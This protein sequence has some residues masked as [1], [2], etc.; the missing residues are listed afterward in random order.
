MSERVWSE[1]QKAVFKWFEEGTGNLIVRARA[2]T[3]KTT[4]ILEAIEHAPESEVLLA[5]FN[6][7]IAEELKTRLKNPRAQAKTLHSVGV[8]FVY[9]NWSGATLDQDRGRRLATKA[10]GR[11]AP[12]AA[13]RLAAKLAGVGKN[14]ALNPSPADL[15]DVAYRFDC[16]PDDW[17]IDEG[18]TTERIARAAFQVMQMSRDRDGT[19]DFDDMVYLPVVNGW[20]RPK[21]Q[22]VVVDECFPGETQVLLADKSTKT[23]KEIVDNR[24][25]ANV[26]SYDE[27]TGKQVSKRVTDWK[28]VILRKKTYLLKVQQLVR[29]PLTGTYLSTNNSRIRVGQ[30]HLVC[31]EGELIFTKNRGWVKVEELQKTDTLQVESGAPRDRTYNQ[32]YKHSNAGKQRLGAAIKR[33]INDLKKGGRPQV[34][35]TTLGGNG[36]GTT[37][38]QEE[39]FKALG[40]ENGWKTEFVVATKMP[41]GSGYPTNYKIDIAHPACM[42]AVEIDG[43]THASGGSSGKADEKK[44]AFLMSM[45][46]KVLRFKNKDVIRRTQEIASQLVVSACPED[47]VVLSVEEH[48]IDDTYVY[49][50]TVE[51]TNCY[52]AHGILVHNCQ[53]MSLPQLELAR[54]LVKKGGRMVVVGDDRQAIYGFRGADS[55]SLD[56]LK[57][58]LVAHEL[59]LTVTYRCPR[60]IVDRARTLVPDFSVGEGAPEG[61]LTD[62]SVEQM[63]NEARAGDF[64]LSRKN[65]PL[66]KVCLKFIRNGKRAMVEGREVGAGLKSIIKQVGGK[67]VGAFMERLTKWEE[68]N[69]SRLLR[70]G[71]ETAEKKAEHVRDQAETLRNLC[72]GV[73]DLNDLNA[74]IDS[75]FAETPGGKADYIVCSSIHKSKGRERDRVFLLEATLYPGG[76]RSIEE[77]NLNYVGTTRSKRELFVVKEEP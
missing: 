51:D 74:R 73:K 33:N 9:R 71:K 50:I 3:G 8:S 4:T 72:E 1:Q 10:C 54:K 26:L 34:G 12:D 47:A 5:A 68:K 14:V 37:L 38:P 46:W 29:N 62:R 57:G 63:Y 23:L 17:L 45:G 6:K 13:V 76:R 15:E 2:G 48:D 40:S 65:A 36:R 22:L 27:K 66:A 77:D 24:L 16:D 49:D 18:W 25:P 75:L 42:I 39:L 35:P 44:T 11:G 43:H 30:R 61:V 67:T 56:R 41:R 52:Y 28:K 70:T 60:L 7:S 53:D 32:K 59:G 64:I 21:F 58:E 20:V 55:N 69:V 19:I 31:T